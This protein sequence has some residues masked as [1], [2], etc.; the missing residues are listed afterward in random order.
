MSYLIKVNEK[1]L[2][3]LFILFKLQKKPNLVKLFNDKFMS[4]VFMTFVCREFRPAIEILICY[5]EH[6]F[7]QLLKT[8][9]FMF[10][11]MKV[12]TIGTFADKTHEHNSLVVDLLI[13]AVCQFS[14]SDLRNQRFSYLCYY[15]LSNSSII[16][17]LTL[18]RLIAYL[19]DQ[20]DTF[21]SQSS[22]YHFNLRQAPTY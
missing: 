17:K 4:N 15:L 21:S 19:E 5:I 1:S 18:A 6:N 8:K 3:E 13:S 2:P 22:N 11:L 10:I 12:V 9:H 20:L 16:K 7:R 14:A